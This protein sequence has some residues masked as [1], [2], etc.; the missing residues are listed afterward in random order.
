M[1]LIGSRIPGAVNTQR[2]IRVGPGSPATW[3][4]PR[5]RVAAMFQ[6]WPEGNRSFR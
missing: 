6:Y 5:W 4:P 3:P 1:A 2:S